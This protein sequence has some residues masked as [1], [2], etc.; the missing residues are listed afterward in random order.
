MV[1]FSDNHDKYYSTYKYILKENGFVHH[2]QRYLNLNAVASPWTK[3]LTQAYR[4][5]TKWHAIE[6]RTDVPPYM[7]KKKARSSKC[8]SQF[9]VST[10]SAK[11]DI[12]WDTELFLEASKR[13]GKRQTYLVAFVL[14][15]SSKSLNDFTKN[16]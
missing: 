4:Q 10:F 13:K 8:L 16:T 14:G 1:N 5:S 3:K 15:R 11:D 6:N 2:S 7:E 9:E 12:H